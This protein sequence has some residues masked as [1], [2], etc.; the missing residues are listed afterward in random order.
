MKGTRAA[1]LGVTAFLVGGSLL[2]VSDASAKKGDNNA[3]GDGQECGVTISGGSVS[4]NTSLGISANGGTSISDAG[5]GS[6]NIATGGDTSSAG[7]GGVAT[8][9]AN[10]GAVSL[11]D[12]NSGSN[13]GNSIGVGDTHCAPPPVAAEAA[14]PVE[15]PAATA[16]EEAAAVVAL[17]STGVGEFGFDGAAISGIAAAAAAVAGTLSVRRRR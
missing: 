17:P 15:A 3:G 12:I 6:N 1:A 4:N 7:N 2:M 16:P 5:G 10:G 11:G 14:A 9:S 8:S 13:A